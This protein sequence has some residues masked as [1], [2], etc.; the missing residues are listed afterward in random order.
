MKELTL[1]LVETQMSK[2]H[3]RLVNQ[4]TIDTINKLANDP[5]YGPEFLDMYLENLSVLKN[6]VTSTAAQYL[7]AVKFYCLLESGCTY[8][9]AYI[10]VFPER[11]E[12][13]KQNNPE[14]AEHYV[15]KEA[16]RFN[17]SA[18]VN[19]IREVAAI[20]VQLVHRSLLNEAILEQANLMRT[21][22]SEMVRQKAAACLITELKP[23]D[24]HTINLNVSDSTSR[25]VIEE[26]RQATQKLAAAEYQ[27]SQ[28]GVPMKD[29][30]E[31][32]IIQ[33]EFEEVD[34]DE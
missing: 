14:T 32:K 5:D 24:D 6:F 16:S 27:A 7:N 2:T 8:K 26:L 31:R 22:R 19:R 3:R 23:A 13:R 29:I 10:K 1:D 30:A 17:A 28:A 4:D 34:E 33:G 21:A 20:P 9:D 11:Y 25:S 18:L 12:K 15:I